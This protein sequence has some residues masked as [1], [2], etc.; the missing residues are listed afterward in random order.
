M[1]VVLWLDED[2]EIKG[3]KCNI[4]KLCDQNIEL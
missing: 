1:V 4:N 2:G 3:P